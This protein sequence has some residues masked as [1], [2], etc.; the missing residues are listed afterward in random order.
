MHHSVDAPTPEAL[1][2]LVAR[3]RQIDRYAR[4]LTAAEENRVAAL[5]SGILAMR[6]VLGLK[7]IAPDR[8]PQRQRLMAHWALTGDELDELMTPALRHLHGSLV[9]DEHEQVKILSHRT[10][11]GG[12]RTVT[13]WHDGVY[14]VAAHDL[15]E[16]LVRLTTAAQERAPA[17][18]RALLE[19]SQAIAATSEI[20]PRGP[21]GRE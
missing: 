19:R 11:R 4:Q 15:M 14:G 1:A 12:W 13:L 5:A 7:E 2:D 6:R 3:C 21:R 8:L 20:L 16:Y 10:W 9:L 18:A 17:T